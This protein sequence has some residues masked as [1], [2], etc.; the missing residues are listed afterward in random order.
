VERE[1]A[2]W[3]VA[4]VVVGDRVEVLVDQPGRVLVLVREARVTGVLTGEGDTVRSYSVLAS[5]VA[6]D[7]SSVKTWMSLCLLVWWPRSL[8]LTRVPGWR[9]RPV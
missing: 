3:A 4:D 1:L 8:S 9:Q 7:P 6:R 2:A 5:P